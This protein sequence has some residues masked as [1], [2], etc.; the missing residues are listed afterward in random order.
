MAGCPIGAILQ[1]STNCALIGDKEDDIL[2]NFQR[3]DASTP[4]LID[5]SL[6]S[7]NL[8]SNLEQCDGTTS[9]KYVGFDF[10]ADTGARI[11]NMKYNIDISQVGGSKGVFTKQ[12]NN[13]YYKF[14]S[15]SG[16]A[17]LTPASGYVNFNGAGTSTTTSLYF[18]PLDR[19]GK[20]SMIMD[21]VPGSSLRIYKTATP[22]V[23]VQ[24]TIVS[25]VDSPTL[26]TLN[27]TYVGP[28]T[29]FDSG[30][31]IDFSLAGPPTPTMMIAP[32]G[33]TY[34]F[35][36]ITGVPLGSTCTDGGVIEDTRGVCKKKATP[37]TAG[38]P[39]A[40]YFSCGG[41]GWSE[42]GYRSTAW[43]TCPSSYSPGCGGGDKYCTKPV[44]V[45]AGAT[46]TGD[47]LSCKIECDGFSNCKGFNYDAVSKQCTTYQSITS[48]AY[49][50]STISF[51][52]QNFPTVDGEKLIPD[53][54]DS[55]TYLGNTGDDCGKM[56]ECN[57]NLAHVFDTPGVVSFSTTDIETCGFCP[58]KTVNKVSSDY[59]VRDE[60]GRTTKYTQKDA[61]LAAL[62][63]SNVPNPNT[64]TTN[65]N[66]LYKITP[67]TGTNS[68]YIFIT[69]S[70][71]IIFVHAENAVVFTGFFSGSV[72][73]NSVEFSYI[74]D[75]GSVMPT[76][77]T[78]SQFGVDNMIQKMVGNGT[79]TTVTTVMPHKLSST[80]S[81]FFYGALPASFL[82]PT[83]VNGNI[84]DIQNPESTV[85]NPKANVSFSFS[86]TYLGTTTANGMFFS[87]TKDRGIPTWDMIPVDYVTN[88]FQ[89]RTTGSRY[90]TKNAF[91]TYTSTTIPLF[92]GSRAGRPDKYSKEFAE[93]VFIL[94]RVQ[95]GSSYTRYECPAVDTESKYGINTDKG[96]VFQTKDKCYVPPMLNPT[97]SGGLICSVSCPSGFSSSAGNLI[98]GNRTIGCLPL[99]TPMPKSDYC[100]KDATPIPL[101]VDTQY[102]MIFDMFTSSGIYDYPENMIFQS[103]T[104][105]K[106]LL[107]NKQLRKIKNDIMYYYLIK[108]SGTD[109]W[110]TL[111]VPSQEMIDDMP[112]GTDYT[113]TQNT[114]TDTTNSFYNVNINTN[115]VNSRSSVNYE[116]LTQIEWL[117]QI[118]GCAAN[119]YSAEGI[120]PCT[121]CAAGS[122][123]TADRKGCKCTSQYT[124]NPATNF[125]DLNSCTGNKYNINNGKEPCTECVSGST[126]STDHKSCVCP[127]VPY[128]THTWQSGTNTCL[129]VCNPGFTKYGGVCLDNMPIAYVQNALKL[130]TE[131]I[132]FSV[133]PTA[134]APPPTSTN[135]NIQSALNLERERVMSSLRTGSTVAAAIT[136]V[137]QSQLDV[138]VSGAS[139]F[140]VPCN[141]SA[142]Y[143]SA[144]GIEPCLPCT[145]CVTAPANAKLTQS[146]CSGTSG[147]SNRTC[148]YECNQGFTTSGAG[149]TI[150]CTCLNGSI[151]EGVCYTTACVTGSTYSQSGYVPC[152]AC[153]QASAC[154]PNALTGGSVTISGCTATG[155]TPGTCTYTC[156]EGFTTNSSGNATS[157][158]CPS[159]KYING[160]NQ[161]VPCKP[162]SECPANTTSTVYSIINCSGNTGPGT[163]GATCQDG[164]TDVNGICC[165][166]CPSNTTSTAYTRTGCTSSSAPGT[167][168]ATCQTG[169]TDVNG[170]CCTMCPANTTSTAYT[171][172]GCTS[173]SAP[174]KCTA[175]CNTGYTDV[176]GTCSANACE[177]GKTFS[178]TG[179][180]P[181]TACSPRSCTGT[182]QWYPACTVN[183]NSG[184]CRTRDQCGTGQYA[185]KNTFT[186]TENRVCG[187]CLT[188][189]TAKC[190]NV[191]YLAGSCANGNGTDSTYCK[192]CTTC[193]TPTPSNA[194]DASTGCSGSTDRTCGFTCNRGYYKNAAG[195]ACTEY[196]QPV[197]AG[198]PN[199]SLDTTN[200]NSF[201]T[202][203]LTNTGPTD[204][205]TWSVSGIAGVSINSSTGVL[206]IARGTKYTGS[207]A[208]F[209]VTASN[210]TRS[211]T[212]AFTARANIRPVLALDPN[213]SYR[214]NTNVWDNNY[215]IRWNV[216]GGGTNITYTA[217]LLP[218]FEVTPIEYDSYGNGTYPSQLVP[219]IESNDSVYAVPFRKGY[220]YANEYNPAAIRVTA[221]NQGGSSSEIVASVWAWPFISSNPN[222]SPAS[223]FRM[224]FPNK[225]TG[226]QR[227]T[228][229]YDRFVGLTTDV[230]N[231]SRFSYDYRYQRIS[232]YNNPTR[233]LTAFNTGIRL[234]MYS[235]LS[236]N[237][238][239]RQQWK[240]VVHS[241][242][243]GHWYN[244][245]Y[246]TGWYLNGGLSG[247][248][249]TQLYRDSGN[250][251]GNSQIENIF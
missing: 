239:K 172:S 246:G 112:K 237:D 58:I 6:F 64:T 159:G 32:P 193:T 207:G 120:K 45:A 70:R 158:T 136:P 71:N 59:Y 79:T 90:L 78:L 243:Q 150:S 248:G 226:G 238:K 229:F 204:T 221:T 197:V 68:R 210:Y 153:K 75:D 63:Y 122:I 21:L 110:N 96:R 124:W 37:V 217:V 41:N 46:T 155:T 36:S 212:A 251:G 114:G 83:I 222:I 132:Q 245:Y 148:L 65:L 230:N 30:D 42:D 209:V 171:R 99:L 20:T 184:N 106:Y 103:L 129:L 218:T 198:I 102:D 145:V 162:L 165:R 95:T 1:D 227:Y 196:E 154:S 169:Y 152:T 199:F 234:E 161:C 91:T 11:N 73:I 34:S 235:E 131:R 55:A 180:E 187:T 94:E 53:A 22:Q 220:I 125:C 98:L 138:I 179:S 163:C 167:C 188:V 249:N 29:T 181:C 202:A 69:S 240:F 39:C 118:L 14:A 140:S 135:A 151:S 123:S 9:C 92:F 139:K 61:A 31:S 205:I 57:S 183:N 164:Y 12:T 119:S 137:V 101:T 128:G 76:L 107:E 88:G 168:G 40:C 35:Q 52:R 117:T 28:Y 8:Q 15:F 104:G 25:S 185:V 77:S 97:T 84:T 189:A 133:K 142:G 195:T 89:F 111:I 247:G 241:G 144:T 109:N 19:K 208:Y 166:V 33:Y 178:S 105:T 10:Q 174:G 16:A 143:Y 113:V 81:V 219:A 7:P 149:S 38:L 170:I 17:G 4:V 85:A 24:Y 176:N 74:L 115:N 18:S 160:S 126:A 50:A 44:N 232:D 93:T 134:G 225:S 190:T 200:D 236:G 121:V 48:Y 51:T 192:T 250:G 60:V 130:E 43:H 231:A 13:M 177:D 66:A 244:M 214:I 224:Y 147:T 206:T 27:V 87:K 157:C 233:Y 156:N 194:V 191:Q 80:S 127:T 82:I 203:R 186:S 56:T 72:N 216:S 67:Y 62:K 49:N 211:G 175:T 23:Y 108:N 223:P 5:R 47:I 116:N 141:S 86:S 213:N 26:L 201:H 2:P 146:G 173:S 242:N 228:Y 3:G 100:K 215:Y 54:K 182:D